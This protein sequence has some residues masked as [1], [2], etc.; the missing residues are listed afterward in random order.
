MN[1]NNTEKISIKN[2][3]I[4]GIDQ[5]RY[6]LALWVFLGHGGA[7]PLFA[8]HG[9]SEVWNFI[10]R[11]YGWSFNGQA[12]VIVFFIISGFCIHWPN[13]HRS[14]LQV[15]PFY[16]A[17]FIRLGIPL[18]IALII[19]KCIGY[20][21]VD[22]WMYAVPIWTLFCESF[23]YLAYPI[24]YWCVKQK[25]LMKMIIASIMLSF[26]LLVVWADGREM[27]FH[28][29]GF[30]GFLYWRIS[31][32]ALPCWLGG[33]LIAEHVANMISEKN[34]PIQVRSIWWWRIGALIL[35]VPTFPLYRIGLYL[36]VIKQP[37]QGLFFSNQA[38]LMLFGLY[39][40]FWIKK[41]II[42]YNLIGNKPMVLFEKLGEASYS[43]YLV[44]I[45]VIWILE[46]YLVGPFFP[47]FII[48][49]LLMF[50]VVHVTMMVFHILIERPSHL[51]AK[52]VASRLR[53]K[54]T[55]SGG[56]S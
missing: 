16:A 26:F 20:S 13:I 38:T 1:T 24:I 44:H 41:E 39:A 52:N 6:F 50:F 18:G 7:P 46:K 45:G 36:D 33:V 42:H 56:I 4:V 2:A 14:K 5:L 11:F 53:R 3:R 54:L 35:S 27:Y 21:K 40:Y 19:M 28:E 32:V 43:L 49:C 12:A 48:N 17:R 29:G 30:E 55:I 9:P 10:E 8:G 15:L 31:V 34:I 23:Y 37:L 47:G 51:A 25:L 22:W